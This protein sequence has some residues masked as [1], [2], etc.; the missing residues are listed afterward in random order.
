M[1][2]RRIAPKVLIAFFLLATIKAS[3]ADDD[4]RPNE[5][6]QVQ[7]PSSPSGIDLGTIAIR[8][9]DLPSEYSGGKAKAI[10][11]GAFKELPKPGKIVNQPIKKKKKLAGGTTILFYETD[12]EVGLAYSGIL[13]GLGKSGIQ[14][15]KGI[16]EK[17]TLAPLEIVLAVNGIEAHHFKAYELVFITCRAVVD[18]RLDDP[19]I[20]L[21]YAGKLDLRIRDSVACSPPKQGKSKIDKIIIRMADL[22]YDGTAERIVL[23]ISGKDIGTPFI[24]TIEIY[25]GEKRI[26]Y[27]TRDDSI[28]DAN[29]RYPDY[30]G[31]CDSYETCKEKWYF[32][33]MM[34]VFL[35]PIDPSFSELLQNRS[36][37]GSVSYEDIQ[38]M[39]L[40]TGKANLAE[41]NKI[42]ET[43]NK[44][45]LS[46]KAVGIALEVNPGALGPVGIWIPLVDDFV[47]VYN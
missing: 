46:R 5:G 29:F 40:R 9:G 37:G 14:E 22:T 44:E 25:S 47:R 19:N 13:K 24:W 4:R 17:A 3:P 7:V 28:L 27:K 39:I 21:S 12:E 8:S 35:Y 38:T 6:A 26:F 15:I 10:V 16:G 30:V 2:I 45:I 20:V 11:P 31:D 32:M 23:H 34:D 1:R 33:D 36:L 18:I 43:L 41:A 42:I